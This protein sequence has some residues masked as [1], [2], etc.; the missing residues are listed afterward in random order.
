MVDREVAWTQAGLNQRCWLSDDSIGWSRNSRFFIAIDGT[1][2]VV[3]GRY[4][5]CGVTVVQMDHIEGLEPWFGV[6]GNVP[7]S[8]EVQRTT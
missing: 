5:A 6:G 4:A 1:F 8:F 3:A 2:R 7:T